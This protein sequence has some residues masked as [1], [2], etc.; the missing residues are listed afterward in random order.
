MGSDEEIFDLLR[1]TV[2]KAR[3]NGG[4]C[5]GVGGG[6]GGETRGKEI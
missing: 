3:V 6:R 1:Y 5:E 4:V 2:L